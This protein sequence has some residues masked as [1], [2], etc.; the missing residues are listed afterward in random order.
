[1]RPMLRAHAPVSRDL[2]R[3]LNF[4]TVPALLAI[5]LHGKYTNQSLVLEAFF[6]IH[7]PYSK[8]GTSNISATFLKWALCVARPLSGPHHHK[9]RRRVSAVK[10]DTAGLSDACL[11]SIPLIS[12]GTSFLSDIYILLI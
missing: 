7:L 5:S 6:S 9:V 4:D 2:S 3:D 1:M 12:D 8:G 11:A 10:P